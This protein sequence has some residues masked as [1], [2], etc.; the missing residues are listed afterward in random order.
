MLLAI[1]VG[2]TNIVLGVYRDAKLVASW[3]VETHAQ[4]LADEYA[5]MIER[6]L[7]FHELKLGDV[8]NLVLGSVVPMLTSSLSEFGERYLRCRPVVVGPGVRTGVR[9]L[10]ENPREVGADRLANT[11][12]AHR[13]YGGPAIVVDFGTATNFDVVS[14]EGDFLGGAIAP[15][16]VISMQALSDRAARLYRIELTRPK[17][18]IGKN[19]MTNMQSGLIFGYVGLVEGL[20]NRIKSELGPAKVIFTGGLSEIIARE[21][22]LVD[23]INPHLT[24]DGLRMIFELN[25]GHHE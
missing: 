21:T 4:R 23:T 2:N 1:D 20:I 10:V 17:M 19:T 24:L 15:G 22:T 18:A 5:V 25:D 14:A 7:S 3:R 9:I 11:L 16:L 12:A 8:N 13:L 6:L